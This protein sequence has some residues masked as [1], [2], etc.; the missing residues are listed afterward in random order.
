MER[1]KSWR[2]RVL[3]DSVEQQRERER[4]RKTM[5]KEREREE[6]LLSLE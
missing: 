5:R 4:E 6:E 2:E 1:E 3:G